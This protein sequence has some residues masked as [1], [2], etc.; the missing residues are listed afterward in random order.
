VFENNCQDCGE[1][2]DM[3]HILD[4]RYHPGLAVFPYDSNIGVYKCCQ[5][6]ALRFEIHAKGKGCMSK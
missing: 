3:A 6:K 1:Y 5:K 2:F 4:C